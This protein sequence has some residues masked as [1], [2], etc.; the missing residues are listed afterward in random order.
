M[1]KFLVRVGLTLLYVWSLRAAAGSYGGLSDA[2]LVLLVTYGLLGAIGMGALWAPVV[3]EKLS[4]PLTATLTEETS[5]PTDPNRLV[6]WIRRLQR[7]RWHRLALLLVLL[8][9]LR[10]PDLPQPALLGLRSVRPG[11]W[12]ERWFAR[13]VFRFNNIQ[14]CLHAYLILKQRHGV[15]PPLHDHPEVNLAILNLC[16]KPPPEPRKYG[17]APAS[18]P[19]RPDRNRRIE[20]FEGG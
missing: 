15:T 9:G 3:G 20:L 16:R 4:D 8:E 11:S 10:H 7:R 19:A 5:L 18:E 12:L 14:N 1:I 13:E 2:G 6:R 17:L